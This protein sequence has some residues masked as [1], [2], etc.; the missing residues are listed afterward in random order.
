MS[1]MNNA[2]KIA[3]WRV[4][5]PAERLTVVR[6]C[7]LIGSADLEGADLEGADLEGANLRGANLRGANLR[8]ADL[9][10]ANLRYA[11]LRGA[12]LRD[13]D[14][15]GA[16]LRGANLRGA[17]LRGADLGGVLRIDGLP[18]GQV[19]LIPTPTGW[20]L[21]VGCWHGTPDNLRTLIASDDGWP[22]A[23]GEEI[24][25]RRPLLVAALSLIDAHMVDRGQV[26]TD[27]AAKWGTTPVEAGGD[28]G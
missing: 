4:D 3:A 20:D 10:Y 19:T 9:R 1:E 17:N 6:L 28:R 27:L 23:R 18:S 22:E 2:E 15:R 25:R 26:I 5:H 14:L 12:N 13:A 8:Y 16:N 7:D 24:G 11:N 21:R